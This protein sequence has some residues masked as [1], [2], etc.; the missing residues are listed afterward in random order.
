MEFSINWGN[1][2]YQLKLLIIQ[3][4]SKDKLFS[5]ILSGIGIAS[6]LNAGASIYN[7]HQRIEENKP[8]VNRYLDILEEKLAL[9]PGGLAARGQAP[10]G[11]EKYQSGLYPSTPM[12]EVVKSASTNSDQSD[13]SGIVQSK[14]LDEKLNTSPYTDV[15]IN[16]TSSSPSDALDPNSLIYLILIHH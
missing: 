16:S 14:I 10:S 1:S 13:K 12:S 6:I 2:S 4:M 15:K 7:N 5:T 9:A 11:L 3:S 8:T